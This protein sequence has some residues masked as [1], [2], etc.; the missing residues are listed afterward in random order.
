MHNAGQRIVFRFS[1]LELIAFIA[2]SR[3]SIFSAH[4]GV[5]CDATD[6][7]FVQG[8]NDAGYTERRQKSGLG[9]EYTKTA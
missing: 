3:D 8:L 6:D 7:A 4:I 5:R 1:T 9:A 2:T